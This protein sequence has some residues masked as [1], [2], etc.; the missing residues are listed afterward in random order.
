MPHG[1][2]LLDKP[3]GASSAAALESLKARFGKGAKV[4]HAGTLDPFAT[5]LLIALV[6][7]AT[8]LFALAASLTK[9]YR[10]R[11]R[12]GRRTDTLDPTGEVVEERDAGTKPEGLGDAIRSQVGE[13]RQVPPAFSAVKVEGR[14]AYRL[15]RGGAEPAL[16]ARTVTV[17]GIEVVAVAWPCVDLEIRC[18]AGTYIR[19]IARDVGAALGL[20]A[21]LAALRRTRI[22]PFDV[23]DADPGRLL[24]PRA[25]VEAAELPMAALAPADARRFASG[26]A[27][28]FAGP[29]GRWG[30]AA[31]ELLVGIGAAAAGSLLPEMVL[32]ASRRELGA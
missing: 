27:V 5:G 12:F 26:L 11:V 19:A 29:D 31:G 24:P 4:G 22:G 25:L 28:P 10:A 23:A 3:S 18:G 1:I 8:R 32:A 2:V 14:R 15:A 20:P 13:I 21:S 6:G 17:H 30:V 9:T 16:A 7:D